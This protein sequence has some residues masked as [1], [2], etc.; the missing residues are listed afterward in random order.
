MKVTECYKHAVDTLRAAGIE[1]Y[2]LDAQIIVEAETT[3]A[4]ALLNTT[5]ATVT[6]LQQRVISD[7]INRRAHHEPLA[8]IT[9]HKE[10]YG[11]DFIVDKT[12]L[13]PRPET[14]VLVEFCIKNA[15]PKARVL[16]LGTGSGCIA[17][18]IGV[19]RPDLHITAT[20]ISSEALKTA[21]RNAVRQD[22][23]IH[24][25]MSDLFKSLKEHQF[26][27]ICANLPYVPTGAPV[28][29]DL[30]YEPQTALF[31]GKDGLDLY[32]MCLK[33]LAYHLTPGGLFVFEHDRAQ[34]RA[35]NQLSN[36]I[37]GRR[38]DKISDFVSCLTIQE[39]PQ[40]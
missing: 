5:A 30:A 12:V 32:R 9:G 37:H 34:F 4:R 23:S 14:E 25:Y 17:V 28:V 6:T 33:E 8:Y 39:P 2:L 16:E 7:K 13:I 27:L 40:A 3:I 31:C 26:E 24:F 10:F 21:R 18:A 36:Q 29:A 1:S 22:V 19:N 11:L 38:L 20:D 15:P 35:L